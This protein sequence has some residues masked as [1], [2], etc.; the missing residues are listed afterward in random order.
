[1][2]FKHFIFC[3]PIIRSIA[4]TI[5]LVSCNGGVKVN[6][7]NKLEASKSDSI[8]IVAGEFDFFVVSD[9]GRNGFFNQKEVANAMTKVAE[10]SEPEFIVSCGDNFQVK[11]IASVQDP[12]WMTT[13]E[14]IYNH[15][16]LLADWYPV[17][18]NHDYKGN[19][20]AQIQYSKI[21]R[22]WRMETRYYT[23][24]KKINDSIS[25][26]LIFM[27]TPPLVNEYYKRPGEYP[28]II[29]QDTAK[30]MRW[31]KNTLA[32]AKEDW[33]LIFG[34]HPVY[35]ASPKHGNTPELISRF[36]PLFEKYNA[37]IYF[38]GHDHDLQHLKP[39]NSNVDY[40]VT[41]AG[42]EVRET[43]KNENTK[44]SASQSGFTLVSLNGKKLTLYFINKNGQAIY[45]FAR[46]K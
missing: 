18:G 26:R 25:V 42:S 40:I 7:N 30:E 38:C 6:L 4:Y 9:W 5:L 32:N 45:S 35:S 27:D 41:G 22:R 33:I 19:T 23:L 39:T 3:V 13:F 34:H 14:N 20:D 28:D 1:M 11:G 44:F 8:Q 16:S 12:L 29:K 46:Q 15:P 37:D 21:S 2:N 10:T 17:L 36:K 31:L 24:V 43:G